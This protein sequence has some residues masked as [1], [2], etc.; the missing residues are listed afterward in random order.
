MKRENDINII[1]LIKKEQMRIVI[2]HFSL[3]VLFCI[4]PQ[5]SFFPTKEYKDFTSWMI[6]NGAFISSKL[7]PIENDLSNRYVIAKERI[8]K[9]E[10][11]LFV[12]NNIIISVLNKSV[13]P[14]CRSKLGYSD[15]NDFNCL[16]LFMLFDMFDHHSFFKPYYNYMPDFVDEN[17]PI[18]YPKELIEKYKV[19][20]LDSEIEIGKQYLKHS[21]DLIKN[22]MPK[23]RTTEE[24]EKIFQI[25]GTRNF[26]RRG[27]IF[28]E[29]NSM[30]PYLDLFNHV[31]NF[32]TFYHFSDKR[33]GYVLFATRPIEKNEEVTVSYGKR[34]NLHLFNVYGFTLNNNEYKINLH[35]SLLGHQYT[36]NGNIK[37]DEIIKIRDRVSERNKLSYDDSLK[38]LKKVLV[39]RKI[40]LNKISTNNINIIN[41]INEEK[42]TIS[43]YIE[44]INNFLSTK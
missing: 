11:I 14:L 9:K 40:E 25:V 38:Q 10:E 13:S 42:E 28:H 23:L 3:I 31:N 33:N 34:N 27:S 16:V 5:F 24:F 36:L 8:E 37:E 4:L 7:E 12:P 26:G 20:E 2:T 35:V 41:I 43:K 18:T 1:I 29:T 15:D 19:T 32:N 22:Y 17:N 6:S 44:I 30:V 21:F 39:L